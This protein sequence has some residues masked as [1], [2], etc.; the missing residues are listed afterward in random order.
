MHLKYHQKAYQLLNRPPVLSSRALELLARAEQRCG[1][2][3]PASVREWYSLEGAVET[4]ATHSNNDWPIPLDQLG[5]VRTWPGVIWDDF[6]ADGFLPIMF[7]NQSVCHWAVK[8][9]GS[10]DPP[11]VVEVDSS[12]IVSWQIYADTFSTFVYTSIW[13]WQ[14]SDAPLLA[15]QDRLLS[16]ADLEFLRRW[17][18]EGPPTYAWPGR[19]TYRFSQ[20]DQRIRIWSDEN[21]ADWFLSSSTPDSLFQ[22]AQKVWSLGGL[23]KTLYALGDAGNEV[24]SRIER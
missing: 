23:S 18:R 3:L 11:V 6:I 2:A 24:L 15:A 22:L 10:D 9:D 4:L 1:G 8:L 16:Q 19:K 13:D 20:G 12:P 17:Y 7:E 14:P 21:Q 5:Q